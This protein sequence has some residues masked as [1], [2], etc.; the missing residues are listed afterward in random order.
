MLALSETLATG[1]KSASG[2]SIK[3]KNMWNQEIAKELHKTIIRKFEKRKVPLQALVGNIRGADL[4]NMQLICKFKKGIR[5]LLML[6]ILLYVC[7]W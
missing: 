4:V 7:L 3:N 2:S 6:L 5:F 1:D